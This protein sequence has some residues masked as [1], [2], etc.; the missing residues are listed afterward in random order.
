M[1]KKKKTTTSG[2]LVLVKSVRRHWTSGGC[3]LSADR[4]GTETAQ[5]QNE[6]L[7]SKGLG[8][9]PRASKRRGK[10]RR[11]FLLCGPVCINTGIACLFSFQIFRTTLSVLSPFPGCDA[12]GCHAFLADSWNK[13]F[14]PD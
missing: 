1:L 7:C 11:D 4:S 2:K 9:L 12:A 6:I 13:A 14:S 3:P 10:S 5:P 8:A